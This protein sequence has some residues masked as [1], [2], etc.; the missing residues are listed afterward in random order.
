MIDEEER[1]KTFHCKP[2]GLRWAGEPKKSLSKMIDIEKNYNFWLYS[3]IPRGVS[4]L[5]F[6]S[7]ANKEIAMVPRAD[8][9][10]AAQFLLAIVATALLPSKFDKLRAVLVII[11]KGYCGSLVSIKE[12]CG[13]Q[14]MRA[15]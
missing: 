9:P 10:F 1:E 12:L 6:Y 11:P 3:Y 14:G 15:S 4:P 8:I 5:L 13:L 2:W 7:E